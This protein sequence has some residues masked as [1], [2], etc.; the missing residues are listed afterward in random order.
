MILIELLRAIGKRPAFYLGD[1][2]R[3]CFSIWQLRSFLVGFQCGSRRHPALDGDDILDSLM[4]WVCMR[5]RV[6]DGPMDWAG[7][8]WRQS[9]ENDEDAFR[10]FF[11]LFEEYISDREQ[12]GSEGIKTRFLKMLDEL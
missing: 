6:P 8:I 9:G 5:Y 11:E 4:F 2:Q 3:N 10:L 12:L 1:G 7:H